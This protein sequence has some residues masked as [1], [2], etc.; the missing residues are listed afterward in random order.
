MYSAAAVQDVNEQ[1]P[2]FLVDNGKLLNLDLKR[3]DS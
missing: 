2:M 1:P 3:I